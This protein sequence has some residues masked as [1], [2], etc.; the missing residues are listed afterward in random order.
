LKS[1]QLTTVGWKQPLVSN[2]TKMKQGHHTR[3]D[4]S[5]AKTLSLSMYEWNAASLFLSEKVSF[6]KSRVLMIR[7]QSCNEDLEMNFL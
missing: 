6:R 4:F 2:S 7:G 5:S 3:M 1:H